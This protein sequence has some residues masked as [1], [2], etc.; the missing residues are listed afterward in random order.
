MESPPWWTVAASVIPPTAVGV[1]SFLQWWYN[2]KDKI[3]ERELTNEEKREAELRQERA[4]VSKS[5]SA[6]LTD[7]R[8]DV[9]KYRNMINNRN[10]ETYRAWDRARFWHQKAW[11]MRNEAAQCRQIIESM[12]R[13]SGDQPPKWSISLDLPPFDDDLEAPRPKQQNDTR[14]N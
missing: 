1:W 9:D 10:T 4:E 2:R 8:A 13:V 7:L 11:D 14:G 5:Y 3:D 6:L 12:R